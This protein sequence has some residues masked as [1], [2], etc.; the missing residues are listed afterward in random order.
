M[1]QH[2]LIVDDEAL[3]REI[4]KE[5]L[6]EYGYRVSVA[7]DVPSAQTILSADQVDLLVTDITLPGADGLYL[8]EHAQ[9]AQP[10]LPAIVITGYLTQENM[11]RTL[12]L[13][14]RGFL[15]KPFFYD[16]LFQSVEKVLKHSA[17][18]QD[19]LL[20]NRYHPLIG[21]G[22]EI[23]SQ[24]DKD[25]LAPLQSVLTIALNHT[26]ASQAVVATIPA[27]GQPKLLASDG[28]TPQEEFHIPAYLAQLGARLQ[29][30]PAGEP[31][32]LELTSGQ[33]VLAARLHGGSGVNGFLALFQIEGKS[34][35]SKEEEGLIRLLSVQASLALRQE[36]LPTTPSAPDKAVLDLLAALQPPA[37]GSWS[38]DERASYAHLAI[39]L[40]AA[41]GLSTEDQQLVADATVFHDLGKTLLPAHL[42]DK[43]GPLTASERE[44]IQ[45]F[46]D[47]GAF[48]LARVPAYRKASTLV[49]SHR[50]RLD[51]NGY[52]QGTQG[53]ALPLTAQIVGV[54]TYWSAL[55][56][57]RPYR[58]S[59]S[60]DAAIQVMQ[61]EAGRGY[62]NDVVEKLL[63]LVAP[64][65]RH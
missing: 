19:R 15:T 22:E 44:T 21:L 3:F 29:D 7:E 54:V 17:A 13:G 20:L 8:V 38:G 62:R 47:M 50:E 16:E 42:L 64:G 63:E 59:Y 55:R 4:C 24:T 9:E 28:F 53:G 36:A 57:D 1:K 30:Q 41:L 58:G 37:V 32:V 27:T 51:G 49:L 14:V 52:P 11:L 39:E 18:T 48:R 25:V 23:L 26:A 6:E 34:S 33:L 10:D 31:L 61:R 2:I 40:A 56:S 43:R 35:F 5:M 45:T 60:R 12:N 46:V 65:N